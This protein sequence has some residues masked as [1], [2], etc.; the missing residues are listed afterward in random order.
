MRSGKIPTTSAWRRIS[1]LSRFWGLFDPI[2][3][4]DLI[5]ER[6]GPQQARGG[7]CRGVSLSSDPWR[8]CVYRALLQLG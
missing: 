1:L 4:P 2:L 7:R 6:S 8:V 5:G 3:V